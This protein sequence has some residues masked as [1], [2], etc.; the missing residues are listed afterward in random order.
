[1]TYDEKTGLAII[2]FFVCVVGIVFVRLNSDLKSPCEDFS[3]R[4]VSDVPVRCYEYYK[5]IK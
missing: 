5:I 4:N 3:N 1:M 2:L